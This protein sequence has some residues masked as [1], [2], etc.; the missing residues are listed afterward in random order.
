[1]EFA[2][3]LILAGRGLDNSLV[4]NILYRLGRIRL[5]HGNPA[6]ALDFFKAGQRVGG[7]GSAR[8]TSILM[9][10]EAWAHATMGA[11]AEARLMV[12]RGVEKFDLASLDVPAWAGFF[13]RNDMLAMVGTVHTELA[14][15]VDS[16]HVRVAIPVLV[17]ATEG[18][19]DEMARSRAF[20]L[21]MLSMNHFVGGDVDQGVEVGMRA[22]SAAAD[23]SS[24]RVRD[25]MNPLRKDAERHGSHVGARELVARIAAVT[26]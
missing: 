6:G 21:I 1:M 2:Q 23:L 8:D 22:L 17:K 14:H 24:V 11:E 12:E 7:T 16:R 13:T 15:R 5:H 20:S 26:S 25:R 18:Y 3:A 10:N 19:G 4:A 9:M